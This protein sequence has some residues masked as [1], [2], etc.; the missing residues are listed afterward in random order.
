[1]TGLACAG[2]AVLLT[3][4]D[5]HLIASSLDVLARLFDGSRVG[6]APL[7]KLLGEQELRPVTRAVLGAFEG[8]LFGAGLAYGLTHRPRPPE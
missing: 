8:L 3:V 6:L 2:T 4:A 5:R 1:V 7:A